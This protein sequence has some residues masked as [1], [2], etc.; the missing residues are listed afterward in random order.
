MLYI[1]LLLYNKPVI[2]NA[3]IKQSYIPLHHLYQP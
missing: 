3:L 2:S 1:I